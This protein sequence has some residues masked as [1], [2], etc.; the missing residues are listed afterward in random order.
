MRHKL[1]I[2]LEIEG[3]AEDAF[4]VVDSLLDNGV[5]QDAINAHDVEGAGPLRVKS[6]VVRLA[7]DVPE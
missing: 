1:Y 2:I 7:R 6:A 5:P 3:T 4:S